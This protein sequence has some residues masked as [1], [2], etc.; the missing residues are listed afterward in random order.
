LHR[1]DT[2]KPAL[3]DQLSSMTPLKPNTPLGLIR[4][5]IQTGDDDLRGNGNGNGTGA[6]ADVFLHDNT[7]F[8][9]TLHS[10]DDPQ[11]FDNHSTHILDLPIPDTVDPPLTPSHGIAGVRINIIENYSTPATSDNWN[12][13]GLS[14]SLFNDP[15]GPFVCQLNLKGT[16][17]LQDGHIGL[18][19][20]S[21][22]PGNSGVGPSSPIFKT[23]PGSGC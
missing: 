13:A 9:V 5:V 21:E 17:T 23:G 2:P 15:K 18:V 8:S 22:H 12:I 11:G 20:L 16:S 1:L 10:L 7:S 4:F 14:V 19:R 3:I 6:T